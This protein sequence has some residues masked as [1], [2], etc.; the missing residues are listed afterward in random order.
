MMIQFRIQSWDCGFK[1]LETFGLRVV[2]GNTWHG[3]HI[4]PI[5]DDDATIRAIHIG[6]T[7]PAELKS[8]RPSEAKCRKTNEK[9]PAFAAAA[10]VATAARALRLGTRFVDVD[11]ATV[12]V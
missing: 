9:L 4:Q 3:D 5:A 1:D 12:Q 8:R 11:G 7:R 2:V 6:P 10:T